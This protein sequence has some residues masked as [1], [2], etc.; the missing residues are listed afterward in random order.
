MESSTVPSSTTSQ[1]WRNNLNN[2]PILQT[3]RQFLSKF[4]LKTYKPLCKSNE[5][6]GPR[7]YIWGPGWKVGQ[8]TSFDQECLKWQTYLK[9]AQ[10]DF[11]IRDANEP[12]MSPSGK[13]PILILSEGEVLI[14]ELIKNYVEDTKESNKLGQLSEEQQADSQAFITLA[15]TKLRHALLYTLWCES[16][17]ECDTYE[18]YGRRYANPIDKILMYQAKNAAIKEM[19]INIPVLNRDDIYHE[20]SDALQALSVALGDNPYFFGQR[21]PTFID[22]VVF[23]YLHI[24]LEF[25]VTSAN[26]LNQLVNK[27]KNLVEFTKRIYTEY[28]EQEF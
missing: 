28:Y 23:S 10:C 18:K 15:D 3:V 5:L 7:L 20:A 12:L 27:H 21:L 22:A 2:N 13:L 24:I 16:S 11:D 8:R 9:I 19:L 4:P 6:Y 25:P 1:T 17:N 26:D 14:D